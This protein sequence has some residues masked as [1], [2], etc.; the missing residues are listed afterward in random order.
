MSVVPPKAKLVDATGAGDAFTAGV[1]ASLLAA[2]AVPSS[3]AWK[4]AEMWTNALEIGSM[5]GGKAITKRGAVA[6]ITG[7]AKVHAKLR[8]LAR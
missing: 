1:I 4:S 2:K 7:L 5:L 8:R 3:V 6:G